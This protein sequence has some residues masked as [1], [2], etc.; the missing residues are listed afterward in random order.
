MRCWASIGLACGVAG[1]TELAPGSDTLPQE[2][3][4]LEMA[5][6]APVA[7]DPKWGC[8]GHTAP[9]SAVALRPSIAINLNI[10][11]TASQRVPAE[12]SVRACNRVDLGCATPAQAPVSV[13]GD[14][15]IHLSL[16]QGFNGFLEI[17]SPSIVPTLFFVSPPLQTERQETFNV[18]SS[19]GLMALASAGGLSIDP[20]LGHL[21]VRTFDCQGEPTGGVEFSNDSGGEAFAFVD[22]L[23][24][25]GYD[26]TTPDGRGGFLNVPPGVVVLLGNE[27]ASGQRLGTASVSVRKGWFT[28]GDLKPAQ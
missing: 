16:E 21:L 13:A 24:N 7:P 2:A 20:E 19:A 28:Y 1:C 5:G 6:S 22:G 12:L 3:A 17:E 23:P 10:T 27:V 4:A 14:G 15:Q 18:V 9:P 26:V 11:E 8:L 25:K